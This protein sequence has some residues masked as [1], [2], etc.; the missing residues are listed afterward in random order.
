[1]NWINQIERKYGHLAIKK[2]MYYIIISNATV[3]LCYY[4]YPNLINQINLVPELVLKGEVWRLVTF[5]FIPP[6]FDL[7]WGI[8]AFYFY[9]LVGIGLE[10]EWG[11]FKFNLYYLTGMIA[12]IIGAFITGGYATNFYLN[13]SLILAFARIYPNFEILVFFVL[14]IKIKY[15]AWL[16][17]LI[18]GYILLFSPINAK[19]AA[20][21]AI[22]NYLLFFG[23]K[24]IEA[25]KLKRQ[26]YYNRKRFFEEIAGT[27]PIHKCAVCGMTER[28]DRR[29]DFGYC[30]KC[31]DDY[32][33]CA[34]H[35]NNHQHRKEPH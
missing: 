15:L 30:K 18:F 2:L 1:M 3:L 4:I 23:K 22:S 8:L 21:F 25:L 17:W 9:Y 11:T 13:L 34:K 35:I 28:D 6:T 26:V 31:G 16:N 33:Y 19:I 24:T 27:P 14:P 7:F 20:L 5:I 12:T 32:E 29:I 10:N